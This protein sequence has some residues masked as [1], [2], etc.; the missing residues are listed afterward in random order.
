M[1][2]KFAIFN[3]LCSLASHCCLCLATP[4]PSCNA[5]VISRP[6][7]THPTFTPTCR[8]NRSN[9]ARSAQF[10]LHLFTPTPLSYQHTLRPTLPHNL[11]PNIKLFFPRRFSS[12]PPNHTNQIAASIT[13]IV[14]HSVPNIITATFTSNRHSVPH[15]DSTSTRLHST[16]HLLISAHNSLFQL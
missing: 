5:T 11:F 8:P 12:L 2:F 9:S 10:P 13:Q 6:K 14:V 16:F 3:P 1:S 15:F 7:L 4:L